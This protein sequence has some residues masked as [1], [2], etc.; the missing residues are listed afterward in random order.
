[1]HIQLANCRFGNVVVRKGYQ[2]GWVVCWAL[3]ALAKESAI[4]IGQVEVHQFNRVSSGSAQYLR[5]HFGKEGSQTC[6]L[7]E[8]QTRVFLT[9]PSPL[10]VQETEH[11]ALSLV[12]S[13]CEVS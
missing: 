11:V 7:D 3:V 13:Q 10:D 6:G 8:V 5:C 1:M 4:G 2:F 9:Q 12:Q